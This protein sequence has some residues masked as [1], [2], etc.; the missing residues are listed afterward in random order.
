MADLIILNI[1]YQ[2]VRG[3]HTK[4]TSFYHNVCL[5]SFDI[6]TVSESWLLNGILDT[7]IVHE[8]YIT[9]HRD[10]DYSATGQRMGRGVLFAFRQELAVAPQ[11]AFHSST[12]DAWLTIS[13]KSR[14][15]GPMTLHLCVLYI[16]VQKLG[17]SY[18]Q[19]LLYAW[20][21]VGKLF[22]ESPN[23]KYLPNH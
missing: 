18:S 2:N 1:Y 20:L 22:L 3:L 4:T 17:F 5:N 12:E 7:E 19:Q 13:L 21:S 10:P 8:R 11:P 15:T 6:I 9:F 23:D 14:S 16:C